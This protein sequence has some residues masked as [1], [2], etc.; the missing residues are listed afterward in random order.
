VI[1]WLPPTFSQLWLKS[2][3][4]YHQSSCVSLS[5]PSGFR[6]RDLPWTLSP[7]CEKPE[8]GTNSWFFEQGTWETVSCL[9]FVWISEASATLS[10]TVQGRQ[11]CF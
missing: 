9:P 3:Y 2:R 1:C 4:A 7:N 10:Q 11:R 8:T 5:P 6:A